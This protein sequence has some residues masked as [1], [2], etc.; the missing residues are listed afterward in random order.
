MK[1]I[2][3]GP[4]TVANILNENGTEITP[5][6]VAQ[7]I[8][9]YYWVSGGTS[10]QANIDILKKNGYTTDPYTKSLYNLTKYMDSNDYV[11]ISS[12]VGGD[13]KNIEHHS[14]IDGYTIENGTPVYSMRDPY[15]GTDLKC[16]ATSGSTLGCDGSNGHFT[17]NT[18]NQAVIIL[19]P[20]ST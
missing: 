13:T 20:P 3:C 1:E 19:T 14:Y 6:Q 9:T 5:T 16:T 7:E 17:Y 4:T 18:E 12:N 2:G 15:F 8:P 11:W 10:F